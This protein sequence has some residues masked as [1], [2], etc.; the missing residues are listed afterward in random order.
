M[1][2]SHEFA[3]INSPGNN[4]TLALFGPRWFCNGTRTV[5]CTMDTIILEA[6]NKFPTLGSCFKKKKLTDTEAA[7]QWILTSVLHASK[8]DSSQ[9]VS[10][11][12]VIPLWYCSQGN[13]R[14]TA[15]RGCS[16]SGLES[17]W[18]L[19]LVFLLSSDDPWPWD[20]TAVEP[21]S[22]SPESQNQI[23]L[24]LKLLLSRP[25]T[26]VQWGCWNSFPSL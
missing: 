11:H 15:L 5:Y 3:K 4:V 7:L 13:R 14:I 18:S 21:S 20:H 24:I 22:W 10:I 2:V 16:S 12:F 8:L 25:C 23:H 17:V 9:K 19:R 1:L 6:I 26:Y